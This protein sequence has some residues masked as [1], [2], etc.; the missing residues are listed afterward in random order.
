MPIPIRMCWGGEGGLLE[1]AGFGR[2]LVLR[3]VL[4]EDFRERGEI[5]K[6]RGCMGKT[7]WKAMY[8]DATM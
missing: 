4:K 8:F 5:F 3:Y 1:I 6:S 2:L 7:N